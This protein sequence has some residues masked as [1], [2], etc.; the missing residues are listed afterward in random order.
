MNFDSANRLQHL[1]SLSRAAN[2][3]ARE[4][5]AQRNNLAAAVTAARRAADEAEAEEAVAVRNTRLGLS[6]RDEPE[7][8]APAT[9]AARLRA[10]AEA[11]AEADDAAALTRDRATDAG[12]LL[13]ACTDYA[14]ANRLPLPVSAGVPG[15]DPLAHRQ[16]QGVAR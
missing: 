15:A 14:K 9:K 2:T 5:Q 7:G 4:A 8:E 12:R 13:A 6:M 1:Q 10:R 11:L 3:A 16:A